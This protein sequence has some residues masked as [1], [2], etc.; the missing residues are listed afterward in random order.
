MEFKGNEV[1]AGVIIIAA[2]LA[3][4]IFLVAM[5]GVRFDRDTKPYHVYLDYVGGITEGTLV[6]LTAAS[7]SGR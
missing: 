4:G 6:K 1:K 3:L 7:M 5:L 2:V